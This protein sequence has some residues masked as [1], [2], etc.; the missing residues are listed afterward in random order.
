MQSI[1]VLF[2]LGTVNFYYDIWTSHG[3]VFDKIVIEQQKVKVLHP[4]WYELGRLSS[5]WNQME[6]VL[7]N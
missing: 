1:L 4:D 7:R 2:Y 3:A 5:L 6:M